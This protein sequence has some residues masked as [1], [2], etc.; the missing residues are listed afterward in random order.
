MTKV[1]P[2]SLFKLHVVIFSFFVFLKK[3]K[4]R[5]QNTTYLFYNVETLSKFNSRITS[6]LSSI[7][8][9]TMVGGFV[10][11]S[12]NSKHI[13]VQSQLKESKHLLIIL[14]TYSY[15]T[16]N[17]KKNYLMKKLFIFWNVIK[18][19]FIQKTLVDMFFYYS[20]LQQMFSIFVWALTYF[21][22]MT[23]QVD[24]FRCICIG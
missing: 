13:R 22:R 1:A 24:S 12:L 7:K 4:E 18:V 19:F 23:T 11:F 2:N 5:F 9:L 14:K 10:I 6:T 8:N 20:S 17:F 3:R 15:I 21:I 16:L